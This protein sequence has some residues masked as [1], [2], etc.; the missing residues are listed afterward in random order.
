L[1]WAFTAVKFVY[2]W[3]VGDG[4]N[5]KFWEDQ[6]FGGTSLTIHFWELYVICNEQ[7]KTISDI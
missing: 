1:L 7:R 5:I 3:L 2:Q 6:W 4:R